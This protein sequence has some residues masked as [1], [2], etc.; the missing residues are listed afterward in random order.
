VDL[1]LAMLQTSHR[2]ELVTGFPFTKDLFLFG[3]LGIGSQ[4]NMLFVQHDHDAAVC[5]GWK[6]FTEA[7]SRS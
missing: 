6:L 2:R 4:L 1:L 3:K 5:A 7:Y